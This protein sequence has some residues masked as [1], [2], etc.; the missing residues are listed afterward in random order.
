MKKQ[1]TAYVLFEDK[2][3]L[4]I[5]F[6]DGT[7]EDHELRP[8]QLLGLVEQAITAYRQAMRHV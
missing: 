4:R 2:P 1:Q 7:K 8:S 3:I 5:F 6:D